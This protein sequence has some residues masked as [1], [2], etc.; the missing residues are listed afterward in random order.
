MSK[1]TAKAA[2][3]VHTNTC[4]ALNALSR[5]DSA[6]SLDRPPTA[7]EWSGW[8]ETCRSIAAEAKAAAGE[9]C[10]WSEALVADAG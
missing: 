9:A 2:Q 5:L 3:V 8:I 6:L 10:D 7:E 4:D 1:L